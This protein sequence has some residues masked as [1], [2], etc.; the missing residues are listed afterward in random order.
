M[1]RG[2]SDQSGP[3]FS[4]PINQIGRFENGASKSMMVGNSG[5]LGGESI[6]SLQ[7]NNTGRR[8]INSM[9]KSAVIGTDPR[10]RADVS[11]TCIKTR[12]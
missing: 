8:T 7:S 12:V 10:Q 4:S 1:S 5:P 6:N 11:F 2:T 9:A 3:L